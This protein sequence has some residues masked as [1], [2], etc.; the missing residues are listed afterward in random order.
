MTDLIRNTVSAPT[1]RRT[2]MRPITRLVVFAVAVGFVGVGIDLMHGRQ[3]NALPTPAVQGPS[4]T[5]L[6]VDHSVVSQY[7]DEA[8][9]EPG[10]SVA[11]YSSSTL[12]AGDKAPVLAM[13]MVVDGDAP[14]PGA[15]VAAYGN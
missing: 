6:S 8:P 4:L 12:D 10:A 9:L 11:A 15:S 3:A 14:D 7:V 2:P 5:S 13:G 1:P